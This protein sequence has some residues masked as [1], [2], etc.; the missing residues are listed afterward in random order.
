M[1]GRVEMN[2]ESPISQTIIDTRK[3]S[4]LGFDHYETM[5]N[6][7]QVDVRNLPTSVDLISYQDDCNIAPF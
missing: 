3:D 4:Q 1:E 6:H 5:K 7:K 2:L